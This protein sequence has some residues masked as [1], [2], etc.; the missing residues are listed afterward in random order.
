MD[1]QW[2]AVAAAERAEVEKRQST[3][4]ARAKKAA[5]E[6][7]RV[8]RNRV[9]ELR[10][11]LEAEGLRQKLE[12]EA[13]KR[14]ADAEMQE[15]VWAEVERIRVA[16]QRKE[17]AAAEE[18]REQLEAEERIEQQKRAARRAK[19]ERAEAV[20]R[21]R[22]FQSHTRHNSTNSSSPRTGDNIRS[23]K[24]P[25]GH[26]Q[27]FEFTGQDGCWLLLHSKANVGIANISLNDI[28]K[29]TKDTVEQAMSVESRDI[30]FKKLI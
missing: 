20:F 27:R 9:E 12:A 18:R 19:V 30:V 24:H 10:H 17:R 28:P 25:D 23:S 5:D 26:S 4:V 6:K 29:L 8:E 22:Y 2:A 14:R 3:E 1:R 16:R 21:E 15:S 7:Q 13:R 11:K